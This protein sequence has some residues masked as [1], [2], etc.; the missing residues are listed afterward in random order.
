V[1]PVAAV[2]PDVG[3]V[4]AGQ[5]A[6]AEGAGETEHQDRGVPAAGHHRLVSGRTDT[7][8]Y[9]FDILP[10]VNAGAIRRLW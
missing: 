8:R 2:D 3:D 6:A 5:L 4:E 7:G 10:G 9:A 1:Q